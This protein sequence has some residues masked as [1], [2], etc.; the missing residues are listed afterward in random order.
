MTNNKNILLESVFI[1]FAYDFT[2]K[3]DNGLYV[4]RVSRAA[5][6]ATN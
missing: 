1:T 2:D 3:F 4:F 6:M 5:E